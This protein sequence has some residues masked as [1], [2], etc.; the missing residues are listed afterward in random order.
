VAWA[1]IHFRLGILFLSVAVLGL[2]LVIAARR[3]LGP[4]SNTLASDMF[5]RRAA[6]SVAGR[7]VL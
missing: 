4:N 1:F 3:G 7:G 5:R 2:G 6:A